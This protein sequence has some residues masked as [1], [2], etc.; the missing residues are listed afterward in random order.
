[1]LIKQLQ[2]IRP[3]KR[4]RPLKPERDACQVALNLLA[5]REHSRVELENKLNKKGFPCE[6]IDQA[7]EQLAANDLQSDQR[8]LDDFVRSRVLKGNGPLRISQELRQRGIEDGLSRIDDQEIDWLEV[9]TNTYTKKYKSSEIADA[10]ERAK[11]MRYMQSK[12]FSGDII[13]QILK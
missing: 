1:M 2:Q 8:F 12:G 13:R 10:R 7:L 3:K 5:R 4:P 9:A 11:R 6:Q